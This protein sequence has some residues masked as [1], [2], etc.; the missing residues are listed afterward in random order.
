MPFLTTPQHLRCDGDGAHAGGVFVDECSAVQE[1]I[2]EVFQ[3]F[4]R[5]LLFLFYA[6]LYVHSANPGGSSCFGGMRE[7]HLVG[8]LLT[9]HDVIGALMYPTAGGYASPASELQPPQY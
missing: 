9:K 4:S 2:G 7:G 5:G 3:S 1:P 8:F 6:Y